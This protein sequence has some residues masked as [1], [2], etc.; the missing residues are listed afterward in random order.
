MSEVPAPVPDAELLAR[1]ATGDAEAFADFVARHR[2]AVHRFASHLTRNAADA[3][4]VLQQTFVQ[5]W[6]NAGAVRATGSARPWLFTVARNARVR[7]RRAA[8]VAADVVSLESLGGDAGF[9]D[10]AA[11]PERF[12]QALES[13][14]LLHDAMAALSEPDRE[15]LVLRELEQLPGE[16]V[17]AVLGLSLEAMK[18][19]LHRARLRLV[20]EVRRRLPAG[21]DA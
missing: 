21:G 3:E 19:R 10:P 8:A 6:R 9:A 17:A 2:V 12:A 1:S 5:A 20:A 18:S 11:A 15:V 4:E 16:E 14:A 13:K 7:L